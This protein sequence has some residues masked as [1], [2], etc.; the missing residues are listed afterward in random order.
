MFAAAADGPGGFK[1]AKNTWNIAI[2]MQ[3][4]L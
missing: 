3:E 4:R 2:P 1:N